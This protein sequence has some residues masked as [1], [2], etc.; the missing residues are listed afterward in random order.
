MI[1]SVVLPYDV[2]S[3]MNTA[4]N[5]PNPEVDRVTR[6]E[7]EL[8]EILSNKKLNSDEKVIMYTQLL[9]KYLKVVT[10]NQ[11]AVEL[12]VKMEPREEN[13]VATVGSLPGP[14]SKQSTSSYQRKLLAMATTKTT[15]RAAENIMNFI[16]QTPSVTWNDG[17]GRVSIDNV[18]LPTSNIVDIILDL[19]TSPSHAR[20][21]PTPE[22]TIPVL[23]QL[24]SN[25][26]PHSF[27][28]NKA[29]MIAT[30]KKTDVFH[31]PY[32]SP[33]STPAYPLL[34]T[35][36][37]NDDSI[38]YLTPGDHSGSGIPQHLREEITSPPIAKNT[39]RTQHRKK[40]YPENNEIVRWVSIPDNGGDESS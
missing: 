3:R 2:Y 12:P 9:E 24:I 33:P 21:K 36:P 10:S 28:K 31:T 29:R 17:T 40:P 37:S 39:R 30:K 16:E 35:T 23:K 13:S 25:H 38:N 32:S 4:N 8:Q 22:G 6:M 34:F 20:N 7:N 18:L 14:S 15:Q 19:V 5:T 26:I 11:Q 27:I 1:K